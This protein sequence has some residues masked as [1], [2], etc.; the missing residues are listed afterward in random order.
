MTSLTNKKLLPYY[1]RIKDVVVKLGIQAAKIDNSDTQ[2]TVDQLKL[3]IDEPFLFVIV[4][5][6]KAGKSSFINALLSSQEELCAVAPDPKTD[7]IQQIKYGKNRDE[8]KINDHL[9]QIYYPEPILKEISIV[10]TPGTNTIIENHQQIT[11]RFVP[12]SDLVVFVFEA[13]NPYRQ[14]AWDFLKFINEEWK[15]KV[16]FILQQKDLINEKDLSTNIKGVINHA[17]GQGV[18]NPEVFAV[19]ALD[20]L[21]GQTEKSGFKK[22]REYILS[23]ITGAK[24][25][26]SKIQNLLELINTL[27]NKINDG[28]QARKQQFESDRAFR[29]DVDETITNHVHNAEKQVDTLVGNILTGYDKATLISERELKEG[30]SF[31]RLIKKSFKSIFSKKESP[32]AWLESIKDELEKNLKDEMTNRLQDGVNDL[33][34]NIQ[35]MAKVVELKI[36]KNKTVL[37]DNDELFGH[38]AEKRRLV[39]EDLKNSFQ[40]FIKD[41][42]NFGNKDL[43]A[44]SQSI[45]PGIATGSGLAVIGII[46]TA[47][48]NGA[49]FDITGGLITT[50]GILFAGI[51]TGIKRRKILKTFS[52]EVIDTRKKIEGELSQKLNEYIL[53]IK[54]K[55]EEQFTDFDKLL[56]NEKEEI[57]N[58]EVIF[59]EINAEILNIRDRLERMG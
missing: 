19:S 4:G 9:K 54:T 31:M 53:I 59:D 47:V 40:N 51:T 34:D 16:I 30:L 26:I 39:I 42:E 23:N 56:K 41:T 43:I 55:I 49:V 32:Q 12:I 52:R 50:L 29:K 57:Q 21:E 37:K 22:L 58:M 28:L 24:A 8:I 7:T 44:Q 15:K 38:I 27:N 10:D 5:E 46:L 11:E 6:V 36:L 18:P 14:S 1:E 3:R 48:T 33:A 13:K 35:N 20:E 45:S 2:A 25:L 17:S